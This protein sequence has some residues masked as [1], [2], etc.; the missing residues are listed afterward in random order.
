[1]NK[2]KVKKMKRAPGYKIKTVSGAKKRFKITATG[3][4]LAAFAF[5]RHGMRKRSQKFVRSTRGMRVLAEGC[6]KVVM[7][8]LPNGL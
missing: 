3:K 5:K 1:M 4:V 2:A 8:C 6:A 7:K